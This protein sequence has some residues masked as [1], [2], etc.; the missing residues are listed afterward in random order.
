MRINKKG[1]KI[2]SQMIIDF[3]DRY[4]LASNQ[5]QTKPKPSFP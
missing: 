5:E 3:Y 4:F 2:F 1:S